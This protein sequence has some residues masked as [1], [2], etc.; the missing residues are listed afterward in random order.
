M[1]AAC[2]WYLEGDAND[3]VGKGMAGGRA[4]D[5]SPPTGQPVRVARDT[6]HGQ[7]L[8][9]R[10]H[11]RAAVRGRQAGERFA[12]RNSG[13][14]AVIEGCGDH[15]CEYMTGGVAV[16]LGRT[17]VNFGAGLHRRLRLRAGHWSATSWIATTTS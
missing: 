9:V 13:A 17:G 1:S 8:P 16:V 7:H 11:R 4:D 3:Y 5:S 6:D 14:V 15:C 12:V 10:R 2:A